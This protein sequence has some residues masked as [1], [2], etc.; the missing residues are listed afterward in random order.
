M[1]LVRK[2]SKFFKLKE[3]LK[4]TSSINYSLEK[5]AL[6]NY[7]KVWY[8]CIN[9]TDKFIGVCGTDFKNCLHS[10]GWI[11]GV[12]ESLNQF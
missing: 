8:N 3:F 6:V 4:E 9:R 2:R 5:I 10:G 7:A 1:A 11:K 12:R